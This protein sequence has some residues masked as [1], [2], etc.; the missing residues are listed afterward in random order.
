[1]RQEPISAK[2][3]ESYPWF[4]F[5]RELLIGSERWN[6]FQGRVEKR[7][8]GANLNIRDIIFTPSLVPGTRSPEGE[9]E[10]QTR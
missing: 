9:L 2:A 8:G 7:K 1:M 4:L 3:F 6:A 5:L 10:A